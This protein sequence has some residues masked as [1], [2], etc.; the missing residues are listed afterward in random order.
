MFRTNVNRKLRCCISKHYFFALQS[1]HHIVVHQLINF[2]RVLLDWIKG[3]LHSWNKN[4]YIKD[5]GSLITL[6]MVKIWSEP[7]FSF[8]SASEAEFLVL[9]LP[10]NASMFPDWSTRKTSSFQIGAPE[11]RQWFPDWSTAKTSMV[12]RLGH[13]KNV[14]GFQI[15]ALQKRQWFPNQDWVFYWA[16]NGPEQDHQVQ[17][18]LAQHQQEV[19]NK[20]FIILS[21]NII[22]NMFETFLK[23]SNNF[24]II[25]TFI[26]AFIL[27][28]NH[29]ATQV[30]LSILIFFILVTTF[31]T[32]SSWIAW[33]YIKATIG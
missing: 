3:T 14:N 6:N 28:R 13:C 1:T 8:K 30:L 5:F 32:R 25:L 27:G 4:P 21:S 24:Q 17:L 10:K 9:C 29:V 20:P 31:F 15:G 7:S 18:G 16:D 22:N 33:K 26:I 19:I 2:I 12:S 23:T 11:K